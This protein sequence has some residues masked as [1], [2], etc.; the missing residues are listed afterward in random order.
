[1]RPLG[2]ALAL[3]P[4]GTCCIRWLRMSI[5]GLLERERELAELDALMGLAVDGRGGSAVVEGPAGIGKSRLLAEARARAEGRMLVV[6]GRGSELE[7]EFSFGVVRQLFEAHVATAEQRGRLLMG[8]ASAAAGVFGGFYAEDDDAGGASFAA[9]HG[10]YWLTLNLAEDRPLLVCVDDLHWCDKP[11]LYYLAYLAKR[12]EGTQILLLTGL[13]SAEPGTDAALIGEIT[14][15]PA[16]VTVRPAPLSDKAVSAL[17]GDRLGDLPDDE[18]RSACQAS[19]GGN[20]LLV[21]QLLNALQAEGVRPEGASAGLVRDIGPRAVSRTVLLRLARLP[22]A[23]ARVA[24]SLAVLGEGAPLSA[25]AAAAELEE[26]HVA[27]ATGRLAQAEILRPTPPLGFVH[28][29]VRDAIYEELPPAE[30]ELQH[31]RGASLLRDAGAPAEQTAAQ[32]IKAPPRGE[33][34]AFELLW[35][36][37]RAAMH[38]GAADSAVAYLQR[39]LAEPPP[40]DEHPQ[41]LFE[42]GCA[43]ALTSGPAAAEHLALAYDELEDPTSRATAAGLLG[44]ALMFTGSA[45]AAQAIAR[46]AAQEV[47]PGYEDLRMQLEAF[48][49]MTAYF[50]AGDPAR[51]SELREHRHR[52]EGGPGAHMLAA[53]AAWEMVCSDGVAT[54]CA[55]LAAAALADGQLRAADPMLISFAA[56]VTLVVT[57]HPDEAGAWQ[58][59]LADA[60]RRGSLFAASSTHLWHGFAL[61]RRGE[62]PEAEE[63]LRASNDEFKLWGMADMATIHSRSFLTEVLVERGRIEQAVDLFEQIS[64]TDPGMNST[65]WW[66]GSAAKLRT[67]QGR[68]EL[69][70]RAADALAELCRT[71]PDPARLWWRSLKAE[72]LDKLDRRDEAIEL[73]RAE[74]EVNRAFG[75]PSALGRTLR[76]LGNL[77]RE[78]GLAHLREAAEVLEGTPARLE[79]AKALAA[80]GSALR[81]ARQPTEAREPLRRAL[82]LARACGAEGLVEHVRSELH[83]TGARPRREALGGIDSLTPSERRIVDL[84]AAGQR[85]RD[86]AQE[87]YVTPKT[88]EVHLSAA[89]RKLG[90]SSRRELPQA[91]AAQP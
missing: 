62:L 43:E 32:L 4:H 76:V 64:N 91:L 36:E 58:Q 65:A 84:A 22:D 89:Y 60:Y 47:P 16:V 13:R 53:M 48:E 11:S 86:I 61:L 80:L 77:E 25:L 3:V 15:D 71:V 23:A 83:A 19:T 66:L 52:P 85:N 18:F 7:R 46:R 1:M 33:R 57:D 40:P 37:G 74:L 9:L 20:P 87:L 75:A 6:A 54:E 31:A 8:A 82:D 12:L 79:H 41:L 78:D 5:G 88:V 70:I 17:V 2:A 51:L 45:D 28:P 35:A 24:R 63:S 68:P 27:E 59:A 30:R 34:W 14:Q 67:A 21:E 44:R 69:A 50:G 26:A 42:L 38:A 81:R 39:A 90:I 29:L 73:V 55:A 72:A 10:L 49:Y 56:M